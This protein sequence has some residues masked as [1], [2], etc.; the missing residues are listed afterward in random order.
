MPTRKK[1]RSLCHRLKWVNKI[2]L[3]LSNIVNAVAH[4]QGGVLPAEK[5]S[6]ASSRFCSISFVLSQIGVR[7]IAP[8]VAA[9]FPLLSQ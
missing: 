5:L 7:Q 8:G 9:D 6:I 4:H 3:R 1:W 2:S